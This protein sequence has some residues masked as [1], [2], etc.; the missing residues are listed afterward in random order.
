MNFRIV[1]KLFYI[2]LLLIETIISIR[3][4]FKLLSASAD[5]PIV[6]VIYEVSDVFIAPFKGILNGDWHIGRF[7]IDVDALVALLVYM[8]LAFVAIEIAKVFSPK[9]EE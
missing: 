1:A 7:Y 4:V 3:F 8:I 5:N 6:N 9:P 2:I